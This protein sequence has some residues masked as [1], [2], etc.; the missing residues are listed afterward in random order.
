[1]A[2]SR[3][4]AGCSP[5]GTRPVPCRPSSSTSATA[6]VG[7]SRSSGCPG[8]R[9]ATPTSSS[10]P[11]ARAAPGAPATRPTSRTGRRPASYPGFTTKGVDDPHTYY[12]RRLITDGVLA[13]DA[14]VAHP[15]VDPE[16]IVVTGKSQGGGVALAVAGLGAARPGG[17]H[18]RPVPVPLAAR[19]R[20][21][22]RIPVSGGPPL[23]LDPARAGGSGVRDAG[24][25]RRD[26]V[27]RAGAR[28]RRSSRSG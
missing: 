16:R 25:L 27:R 3:S 10:T 15:L 19:G 23:R 14:A 17:R 8:R 20:G 9:P 22:R 6:A 21:H 5:R 26:A 28:R 2:A 4:G 24:L 18:R 11:A 12:Y 7:R 13:I 1:M